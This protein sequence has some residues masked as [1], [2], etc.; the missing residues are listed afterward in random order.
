MRQDRVIKPQILEGHTGD[1]CSL[2]IGHDGKIYS[3]S[4]DNTVMVWSGESGV[5]RRLSGHIGS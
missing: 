1:V 3:G 4:H 2:A 5:R